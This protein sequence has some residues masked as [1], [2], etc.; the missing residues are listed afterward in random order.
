LS[1]PAAVISQVSTVCVKYAGIGISTGTGAGAT[2]TS[3]AAKAGSNGAAGHF[4]MPTGVAAA[5]GIVGAI[6]AIL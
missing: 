4:A 5:V 6:A 2:A 1:I 3:T